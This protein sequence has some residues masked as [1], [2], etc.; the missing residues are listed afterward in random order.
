M[1]LGLY[2]AFEDALLEAGC[3]AIP[4]EAHGTLVGLLS[5]PSQV[6]QGVWLNCINDDS[7]L[8]M[9]SVILSDTSAL[10]NFIKRA[11][12]ALGDMETDPLIL[13]PSDD[14]ELGERA[15][16][17]SSWCS[18]FLYG[19]GISGVAE[20][21]PLSSESQEFLRHLTQ[22]CRLD[23]EVENN[24]EHE[25]AL[26][27]LLEFSKVGVLN[28]VEEVKDLSLVHTEINSLH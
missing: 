8:S 15:T 27:E 21:V 24:E 16:S 3:S 7:K 11:V 28:L 5:G 4:S 20:D 14:V 17:F 25:K 26:F 12:N 18:G 9:D 1:S 2:V 13:I 10:E 19:F 22:F 6:D 23:F